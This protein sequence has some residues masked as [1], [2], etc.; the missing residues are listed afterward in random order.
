MSYC[1]VSSEGIIVNIIVAEDTTTAEAFGARESYEG[2]RIGEK[3]NPS[4]QPTLEER[5]TALENA[6]EKG[7]SL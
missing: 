5:V 7:L 3:Y 1:I 6:I 4:V 2:A